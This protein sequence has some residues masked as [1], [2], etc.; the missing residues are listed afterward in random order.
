MAI[1]PAYFIKD[2][3][4]VE[5]NFDFKWF[6][7]FAV[8][9]KQK[10]ICSLHSKIKTEYPL[11]NPLEISTKGEVPIGNKLSAF[12]LR[13]NSIP[14][15]CVF[16][17]SKV[18]NDTYKPHTEWI[19]LHPKETKAAARVLHE[20]GKV[21]TGFFYDEESFPLLPKTVF[22]DYIYLK[23]VAESLTV[24]EI[25]S[26]LNYDF[27]T[28]I[29][30]NPRKSINTQARTVALLRQILLQFGNLKSFSKD[31]FIEYHKEHIQ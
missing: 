4:V 28:D 26:V 1:R 30:F 23:A 13:L 10:S 29:E 16:Q 5:K 17:S 31:E 7:G 3:K 14:L 15:E 18:F 25:N 19:N 12:N 20:Q 24:E 9:Q 22:Y 27:F 11:A 21:L 6:S 2:N 8:S